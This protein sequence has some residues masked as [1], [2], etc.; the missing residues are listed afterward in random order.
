MQVCNSNNANEVP[1]LCPIGLEATLVFGIKYMLL[2]FQ[3][4]KLNKLH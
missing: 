3:S 1:I 2:K 4:R